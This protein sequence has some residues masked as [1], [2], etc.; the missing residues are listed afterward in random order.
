MLILFHA[1]VGGFVTHCGWNS[2]LESAACGVPTVA[3]PQYS[4]QGTAAWL[5]AERMGAG[6]RAAACGGVVV[7]AQE[8]ARCVEEAAAP[9]AV[10]ARAAAWKGNV[11]AAVAD[12]GS[13]QRDLTAFLRQIACGRMHF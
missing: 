4:D 1:A 6:V 11:R 3:V 12:G 9:E 10:A 2:T 13:S 5:A 7:E 8:L